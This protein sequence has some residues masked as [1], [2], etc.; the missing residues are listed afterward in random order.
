MDSRFS[1]SLRKASWT[2]VS[3]VKS[4]LIICFPIQKSGLRYLLQMWFMAEGSLFLSSSKI[5]CSFSIRV[6]VS[7][8]FMGAELSKPIC[9]Q[10]FMRGEGCLEKGWISATKK[11]VGL[12][13]PTWG[14]GIPVYDKET[15]ARDVSK[16]TYHLVQKNYQFSGWDSKQLLPIFYTIWSIANYVNQDKYNKNIWNADCAPNYFCLIWLSLYYNER[17]KQGNC[18]FYCKRV[19]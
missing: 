18:R 12:S 13:L 14:T 5:W 7:A 4:S 17:K 1:H 9:L 3:T 10:Y 16:D 19:D 15:H 8:V 11:G 2:R 6:S